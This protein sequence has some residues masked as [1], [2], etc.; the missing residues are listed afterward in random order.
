MASYDMTAGIRRWTRRRQSNHV[1]DRMAAVWNY[2]TPDL[3]SVPNDLLGE[4]RVREM[5]ALAVLL[6][7]DL[8]KEPFRNFEM[9]SGYRPTSA[10]GTHRVER[11]L[12][13][14]KLPG[15]RE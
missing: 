9:A 10:Y 5:V 1:S 3:G 6:I 15:Q 4:D 2:R 11:N 14:A 7:P 8:Q 13:S 12:G